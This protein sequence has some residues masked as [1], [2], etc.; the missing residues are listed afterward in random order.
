MYLVLKAALNA[1]EENSFTFP[2][3]KE[4]YYEVGLE[5]HGFKKEPTYIKTKRNV[6]MLVSC[7]KFASDHMENLT[8]WQ[9]LSLFMMEQMLFLYEKDRLCPKMVKTLFHSMNENAEEV[10]LNKNVEKVILN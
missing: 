10:I 8:L 7:I 6:E 5:G 1:S 4:H 9:E 3:V 2:R